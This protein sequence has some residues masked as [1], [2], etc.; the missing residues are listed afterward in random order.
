MSE[1]TREQIFQLA[2]RHA[3]AT[4][5]SR[6]RAVSGWNFSKDGLLAFAR[7]LRE[8]TATPAQ[9]ERECWESHIRMER[10]AYR[11]RESA[12]VGG[13]SDGAGLV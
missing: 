3:D 13:G 8:L 9:A 7:D 12:E 2:V 4:Q 6:E 11:E 5:Q 10:Q 1:P